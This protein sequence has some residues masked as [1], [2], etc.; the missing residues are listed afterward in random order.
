MV[1]GS[2]KALAAVRAKISMASGVVLSETPM[3]STLR[4]TTMK[5]PPSMVIK[6]LRSRGPSRRSPWARSSWCRV[7]TKRVARD[8]TRRTSKAMAEET[9]ESRNTAA[10]SRMK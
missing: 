9:A 10:V 7:S 6:R 1:S 5:S 8:S 2:S 3:A 4:D